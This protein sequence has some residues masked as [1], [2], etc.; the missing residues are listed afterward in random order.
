MAVQLRREGQD[1]GRKG[2][3][4]QV[5]GSKGRW[6]RRIVLVKEALH[7]PLR[8][9]KP[10][11]IFVNSMS[12]LFHGD[13][14][15]EYIQSV[16]GVMSEASRHIFQVLT[17]RPERAVA[18][19]SSLPWPRNVWLGT[20]IENNSVMER[21]SHLEKTPAAIRFL[22]L[23]PLLAPLDQLDLTNVHWVIVGGESGPR[24]REMKPSWVRQI[25]DQALEAGVP[26]FFK[27][28]GGRNKKAAGRIL[29][30]R[31]W[32]EVPGT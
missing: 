18:M 1:P 7:D 24:A 8:W 3:Y 13:V 22:S 31:T 9:Q 29:D 11:K 14:P 21:L 10:R 28:W 32:D 27:Q 19:A 20:S 2:H 25:R 16:F 15:I 23:E 6:T 12:D 5:I 26:F 17:K 30:G 4:Q